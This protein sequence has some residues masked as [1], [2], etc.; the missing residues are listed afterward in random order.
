MELHTDSQA[1]DMSKEGREFVLSHEMLICFP[2]L[3]CIYLVTYTQYTRR[4]NA[5]GTE[6]SPVTER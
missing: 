3:S 1:R 6:T 2:R 4:R 5:L